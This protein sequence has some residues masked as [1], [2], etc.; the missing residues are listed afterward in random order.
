MPPCPATQYVLIISM[1][2]I[3]NY[4]SCIT[5]T[6]PLPTFALLPLK[7][8][9]KTKQNTVSLVSALRMCDCVWPLRLQEVHECIC[10]LS[11]KGVSSDAQ[12]RELTVPLCAEQV[13]E[14]IVEVGDMESSASGGY[15]RDGTKG[16][17]GCGGTG[18]VRR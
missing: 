2:K 12:V 5:P 18:L 9:N 1:S 4:A 15:D 6:Y 7:T 17:E 14:V 13:G 11:S 10:Q 3:S 16:Q 8:F